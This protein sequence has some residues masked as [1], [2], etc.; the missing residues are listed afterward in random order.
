MVDL[1]TGGFSIAL[2]L[3]GFFV[4]AAVERSHL[5]DLDTRETRSAGI[6]RVNLLRLPSNWRSESAGLVVGQVVVS[7]DYFKT[8]RMRVRNVFGGES[9]AMVT[10]M[11]RAR[12]EAVLRMVEEAAAA[13][14]NAVW[15]VR[16]DTSEIGGAKGAIMV[17]AFAYGTALKVES[18]GADK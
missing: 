3:V 11:T 18:P 15:N 2:L 13:G 14:A 10:L 17:E 1:L 7:S 8:F 5:R 16:I 6:L 4:G 12:R 9:R